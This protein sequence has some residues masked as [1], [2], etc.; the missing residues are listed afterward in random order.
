MTLLQGEPVATAI[1]E[2][3]VA[4]SGSWPWR[5]FTEDMHRWAERIDR[6][7]NLGVPR[8]VIAV[9]PQRHSRIAYYRLGRS[10]I[11]ARTTIVFNEHWIPDLPPSQQVLTLLHELVHAHEEWR[12]G[13]ERGGSYHTKAWREKMAEVGII[14]DHHGH[15]L[16]V[17]SSFI[18]YLQGYG[19]QYEPLPRLT[20]SERLQLQLPRQMPKWVCGC[21]PRGNPAR[22]VYL[23]AICQDCHGYYQRAT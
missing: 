12:H 19:L 9:E 21:W 23:N 16:Q 11:G 8:P 15:H 17:L 2:H 18:K 14:A 20:A 13:R 7:W 1:R 3:Q 5:A 4:Q 10:G 6:D 22:A